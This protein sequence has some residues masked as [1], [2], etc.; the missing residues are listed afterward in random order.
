MGFA[1]GGVRVWADSLP[2]RVAMEVGYRII[3]LSASIALVRARRGRW[4]LGAWLL[5]LSLPLLHLSWPPFTDGVPGAVFVSAEIVLG[6]SMLLVVFDESRA[7][8]K[9]LG[10]MQA[11]TAGVVSAQQYGNMVQTAL[12]ELQRL[13]RTRAASVR[14]LEGGHMVATHAVGVS[15]DFLRDVSFVEVTEDL[16]KM[17]ELP[18][19]RVPRADSAPPESPERL[20]VEKVRQVVMLPVVGKKTPVE[21]LLLGSSKIIQWTPEE[22]E[23]LQ[24]CAR[25]VAIAVQNFRLLEQVLR[26]Q[27]QWMNTFDSVHV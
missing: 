2:L 11:V 8:N 10:V 22:L 1:V 9:R 12:Q 27:R 26:S 15:P 16:T 20:K 13:T 19:P 6:L 7:R 17:L 25:Q 5:A 18:R 4:E 21:L 3:L 24:S 14:L 23:F